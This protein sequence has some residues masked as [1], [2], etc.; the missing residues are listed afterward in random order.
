MCYFDHGCHCFPPPDSTI[1]G[2]SGVLFF[3]FFTLLSHD[4]RNDISQTSYLFCLFPLKLE[5]RGGLWCCAGVRMQ[6]TAQKCGQVTASDSMSNRITRL[7]NEDHK[8]QKKPLKTH[9]SLG[10]FVFLILS[11]M[12][13]GSCPGTRQPRQ[14]FPPRNTCPP[15]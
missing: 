12:K 15:L 9:P 5:N 10:V 13:L 6:I 7:H 8:T 14:L 11:Y 1:G 3:A 4:T 2:I